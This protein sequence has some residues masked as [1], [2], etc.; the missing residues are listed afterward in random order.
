MCNKWFNVQSC[1]ALSALWLA[2]GHMI[3]NNT[4]ICHGTL[5]SCAINVQ[6]SLWLN[7]GWQVKF[8]WNVV[9]SLFKCWLGCRNLCVCVCVC[10]WLIFNYVCT[11]VCTNVCTYVCTYVCR[12][13]CMYACMYNYVCI[14]MYVCM[15]VYMYVCICMYDLCLPTY[16]VRIKSLPLLLKYCT[17]SCSL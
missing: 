12:Y 15:Y 5:Q 17:W 11:Y 2:T 3:S 7:F 8:S 13:A 16:T 9:W 1:D 14:I 4:Y 6:S 10:V